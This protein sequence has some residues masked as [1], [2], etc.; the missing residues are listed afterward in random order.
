MDARRVVIAV[1]EK[2]RPDRDRTRDNLVHAGRSITDLPSQYV[3][4]IT[5]SNNRRLGVNA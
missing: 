3:G 5:H 1:R 2:N 4:G